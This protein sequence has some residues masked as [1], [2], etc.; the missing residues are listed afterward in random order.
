VITPRDTDPIE[1]R[2]LYLD[3]GSKHCR[4]RSRREIEV[5]ASAKVSFASYFN[6]FPAS[7]WKRWTHV[8]DVTLRM[9]VRGAGRVDVYRSNSR[10]DTIH[11]DGQMVA[12]ADARSELSFTIPLT[13]FEDGGWIWFDAFTTDQALS[14]AD[15]D[16]ITTQTFA[17]HQ[18]AVGMTTMRADDCVTALEALGRDE[19]VLDVVTKIFVIDQGANKVRDHDRF[20]AAAKVLGDR[21]EVIEQDNIG[22]SGGF[23]RVMFEG[24]TTT[25]A[26]SVTLMDDDIVLEPESLLRAAAFAGAAARPVIVGSHMFDLQQRTTLLASAELVDLS[27]CLWRTAPGAVARHDFATASLRHTP[28]LHRRIDAGYNGWW[29]CTIPRAVAETVGLPLPLFIKWDDAEYGLRAAAAG[30]ATVSLPG[31]AIWHAAWGDKNDTV[32]WQAYF[33]TRNRLIT[34]AL[35]SPFSVR[36]ALVTTGLKVTL[37]HLLCMQYSTVAITRQAIADFLDGPDRLFASLRT[38]LPAVRRERARH[39]DTHVV[40]TAD[41]PP[42]RRVP[43]TRP[44]H[45]MARS[46]VRAANAVLRNLRKP[47]PEAVD[48]P[49]IMVPEP[50]ARWFVLGTVDSA[51]VA[52]GAGVQFRRR[53]RDTFLTLLAGAIRDYRRLHAAWPDIT[54]RYRAALGDLTSLDSWRAALYPTTEP[55]TTAPHDR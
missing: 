19:T 3:E 33:H 55:A 20:P 2:P 34:A 36:S 31:S 52:T 29:T 45:N 42:A 17:P 10:G 1:V 46:A 35:H 21:L 51:A 38:A 27:T 16:W 54:R 18:L 47:R 23:A 28:A 48:R 8:N 49:H 44:P 9:S 50:Q 53:D 22:G 26:D 30:I 32:D 40:D 43:L 12:S 39:V 24:L 13:P 6:A 25:D 14:I 15:A 5:P 37:Q 7:Y 4:L 41:M 11:V